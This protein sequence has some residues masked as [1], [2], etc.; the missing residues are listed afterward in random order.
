VAIKHFNIYLLSGKK[1]KYKG[2]AKMHVKMA[3]IDNKYL[4]IGSAN[5][6]Y[7]AFFKNYEYIQITQNKDLIN[8]FNKFFTYLKKASRPYRLSR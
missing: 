6:S 7:S 5:Y 8:K 3:I 4:V 2:K 1:Y